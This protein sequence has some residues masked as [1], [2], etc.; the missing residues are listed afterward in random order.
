MGRMASERLEQLEKLRASQPANAL[1]LY[2]I[3]NELFKQ[4]QWERVIATGREYLALARDEGAVYRL[5]GHALARLDRAAEAKAVFLE[6]AAVA[7]SHRHSGM[8][9]EFRREADSL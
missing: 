4:E 7:E 9:E 3:V 8:A 6:G 5:L 1:T 2:M